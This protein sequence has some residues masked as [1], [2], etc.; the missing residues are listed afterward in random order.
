VV[1][2]FRGTVSFRNFACKRGDSC[3]GAKVLVWHVQHSLVA[4]YPA[5]QPTALVFGQEFGGLDTQSLRKSADV[6]GAGA[7]D[8]ALVVR[9]QI[10]GPFRCCGNS[11]PYSAARASIASD[12]E[13]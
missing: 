1:R 12:G 5:P 2:G 7:V 4:H 3:V 9:N 11:T 6:F 13:L 8:A 10:K